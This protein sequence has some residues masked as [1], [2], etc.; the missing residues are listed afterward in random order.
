MCTIILSH[1]LL[2]KARFGGAPAEDIVA[3]AQR[4]RTEQLYYAPSTHRR[5]LRFWKSANEQNI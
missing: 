2:I 3:G 5:L 4:E 1:V